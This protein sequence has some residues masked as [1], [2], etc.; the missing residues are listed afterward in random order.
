M[1]RLSIF[2]LATAGLFALA[3]GDPLPADRPRPGAASDVATPPPPPDTDR[4]PPG[5]WIADGVI[6]DRDGSVYGC[7]GGGN[8]CAGPPAGTTD[9]VE[10]E[11]D[12]CGDVDAIRD[13]ELDLR[14]RTGAYR[15]VKPTPRPV[16]QLDEHAV[17]WPAKSG[18]AA[19]G[20]APG[21]STRATFW[22]DT[23]GDG[24]EVHGL[25]LVRAGTWLHCF[26]TAEQGAIDTPWRPR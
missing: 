25:A 13:A 18:F 6:Y 4:P 10:Q 7:V 22:V 16:D 14:D 8:A 19:L 17:A 23:T 5:G 20:W 2:G 24:F 1:R 21:G 3:C 12:L 15:A 9:E 11:L 26:A